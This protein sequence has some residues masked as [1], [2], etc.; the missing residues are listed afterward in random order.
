MSVCWCVYEVDE[1]LFRNKCICVKY[2]K[3]FASW[4]CTALWEVKMK[5]V[6]IY[7][8]HS[9]QIFIVKKTLTHKLFSLCFTILHLSIAYNPIKIYGGL[10]LWHEK[11]MLIFLWVKLVVMAKNMFPKT[12]FVC[13]LPVSSRLKRTKSGKINFFNGTENKHTAPNVKRLWTTGTLTMTN[14]RLIL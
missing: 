10:W 9:F 14:K 1:R 13:W 4:R 3:E 12:G 7:V 6:Y 8:C 2:V 11:I 5:G